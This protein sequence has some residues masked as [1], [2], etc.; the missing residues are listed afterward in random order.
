MKTE[1]HRVR[2][3]PALAG[4]IAHIAHLQAHLFAYLPH[5]ALF[6][7]LTRFDETGQGAVDA[8]EKAR[9]ARQKNFVAARDQHDHA[10]RQ[11]RVV[12]Q[13]AIHTLHGPLA[14]DRH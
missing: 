7:A 10:G 2:E 6:D 11:T 8:R 14:F 4:D 1:H 5:N 12:V 13:P 3:R 9:R